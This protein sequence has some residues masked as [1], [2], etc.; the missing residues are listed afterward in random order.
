VLG[1]GAG[2]LHERLPGGLVLSAG[3]LLC[4]FGWADGFVGAALVEELENGGFEGGDERELR[5]IYARGHSGIV[6]VFRWV[7]VSVTS[8]DFKVKN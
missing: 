4:G 8:T 2:G 5:F 3:D 7:V 1:G 6:A